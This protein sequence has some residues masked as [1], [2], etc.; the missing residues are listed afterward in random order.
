MRICSK[1][2]AEKADSEFSQSGNGYKRGDCKACEAEY[3]RTSE[4][5]KNAKRIVD[6]RADRHKK[7]SANVVRRAV[8]DGKLKPASDHLCAMCGNRAAHYHHPNGYDK[9]HWLDVVPVCC[10]CHR[11]IHGVHQKAVTA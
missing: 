8:V 1:C 11:A 10:T 7:R 3:R 9:S 6:Q 4:V 5:Y 2:H